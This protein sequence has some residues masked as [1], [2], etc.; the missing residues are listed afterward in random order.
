MKVRLTQLDGKLPN[1]ALMALSAHHRR[2][3]DD[4]VFSRSPYRDLFEP[5]F[6]VVY[7]SAIFTRSRNA[8]EIFA[9]EFPGSILAGTGTTNN[10]TVEEVTGE[11]ETNKPDYSIYPWFKP[12]IGFSQRGCR[13]R[14]SFCVVPKK[15]GRI[16]D[17]RT[18][19]EIWRGE[20]HPKE[21]H[22]LDNDF[23]GQKNWER[24]CDELEKG[25]YKLCLNQGI[26]VRL[27][28]EAGARRLSRLRY[29]DDQFKT[30][31]IYT[32]W[33]NAKDENIFDRGINLLL[34]AGI[35][36]G[37]IMVYMLVGYWPGET[38]EDVFYRF[39]K[40]KDYGVL[41]YPMVFDEKNKTLK[42]FQR[43]VVRRYYQFVEWEEYGR[44]RG[45]SLVKTAA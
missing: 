28:H 39:N 23:F 14:C 12:S 34:D 6:D 10:V 24:K 36:P 38:M 22:L 32:A 8:Q 7:G 17:C 20:G 31:R 25:N 44:K 37:H 40:L 41:P 26:N 45:G 19:N 1:L 4:V 43:W 3:G 35:K 30:R 9:R 5:R 21:L 42:R 13:L 18:I 33:D 15:E 2:S 11:S 16:K 27:I 29:Y